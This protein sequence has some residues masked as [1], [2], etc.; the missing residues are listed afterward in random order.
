MQRL[1]ARALPQGIGDDAESVVSSSATIAESEAGYLPVFFEPR[2]LVNLQLVDQMPSLSPITDMKVGLAQRFP[3]SRILPPASVQHR[4]GGPNAL[5]E[6]RHDMKLSV[7]LYLGAMCQLVAAGG[8]GVCRGVVHSPWEE[9]SGCIFWKS[10][11]RAAEA[12]ADESGL[13][14]EPRY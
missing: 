7:S 12:V 14:P 5:P 11:L 6:P 4:A 9:S 2:P 8:W 13:H 1:T 10:T 3:K